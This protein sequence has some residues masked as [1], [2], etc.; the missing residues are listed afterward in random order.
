MQI[1]YYVFNKDCNI[2]FWQNYKKERQNGA[3]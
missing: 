1:A 3:S 2:V